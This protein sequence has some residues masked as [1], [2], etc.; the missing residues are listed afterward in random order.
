MK[1]ASV[2]LMPGATLGILGGGQLALMMAVEARRMGYRIAV[3]DPSPEA[4]AVRLAD[5][6][7]AKAWDSVEGALEVARASDV[8]TLDTEHIPAA[9]LEEVERICPVRPAPAVLR[10]VQDRLLQKRFLDKHGFATPA[11]APVDDEASLAR[12][13]EE[14][15]APL[16]LKARKGGFDGRGTAFVRQAQDASAAWNGLGGVPCIAEGFVEFEREVSVVLARDAPG[17]VASYPVVEN[18]HRDGILHASVAPARIAE[19]DAARAVALAEA[20]AE[21]LDHV[22]VLAVEMFHTASGA[23]MV[24]ELAPRVHN[25]GHLTLGPAATSQFEQHVRAVLGLPLGPTTLRTPAAMLNLLG[26]LWK[27]GAPDWR[28]VFHTPGASLHLYGKAPRPARKVGHVT[29]TAETA[30]AA[31]SSALRLHDALSGAR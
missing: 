12:A 1:D 3:L 25:S 19:A 11:F 24:N 20:I 4:G 18:I 6:H 2:P 21:A 15:G 23:F 30:E 13:V 29:V 10:T 22:G 7:V 27:D 26:D 28:S 16:V 31:L 17:R 5:V 8:V 9:A 14:L